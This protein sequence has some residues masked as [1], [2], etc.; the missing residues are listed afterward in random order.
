[1]CIEAIAIV[2]AYDLSN[3]TNPKHITAHSNNTHFEKRLV[4]SPLFIERR[5]T[6]LYLV[7]KE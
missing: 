2:H 1:M 4:L 5:K 7:S 6:L 3:D